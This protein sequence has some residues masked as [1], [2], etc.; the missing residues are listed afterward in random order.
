MLF[1]GT[2]AQSEAAWD[3]FQFLDWNNTDLYEEMVEGSLGSWS[4]D[5]ASQALS[6]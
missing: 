4:I 3:N 6:R 5:L 2:T 1:T